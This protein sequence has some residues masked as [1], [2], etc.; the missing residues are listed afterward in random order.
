MIFGVALFSGKKYIHELW[1]QQVSV[2]RETREGMRTIGWPGQSDAVPQGRHQETVMEC[3]M[4]HGLERIG[5]VP[6]K[7]L[8]LLPSLDKEQS[9]RAL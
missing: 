1:S 2:R 7:V 6:S 3:E 5:S 9:T 4:G 8:C